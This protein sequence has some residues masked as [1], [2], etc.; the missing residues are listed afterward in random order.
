MV[1]DAAPNPMRSLNGCSPG[2]TR[3]RVPDCVESGH[4]SLNLLWRARGSWN[5]PV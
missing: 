3:L 4:Q 2:D 5:S 1:V